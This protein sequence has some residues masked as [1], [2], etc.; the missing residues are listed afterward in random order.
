MIDLNDA[1]AVLRGLLDHKVPDCAGLWM[2]TR[3]DHPT[4]S[5][6][7][8]LAL[9]CTGCG[10]GHLYDVRKVRSGFAGQPARRL[11]VVR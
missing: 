1:P 8:R 11:Q 4:D 3:V 2:V 10:A 9:S 6:T 5:T 7:G